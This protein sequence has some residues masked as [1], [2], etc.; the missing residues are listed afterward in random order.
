VNIWQFVLPILWEGKKRASRRNQSIRDQAVKMG[1]EP[2]GIVAIGL[3][4]SDH[5]GEPPAVCGGL[6]EKL[7]D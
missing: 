6:L 2:G 7:F 3:Q 4:A 1:M 5:A